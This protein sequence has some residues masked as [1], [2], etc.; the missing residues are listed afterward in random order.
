MHKFFKVI[1]MFSVVTFAVDVVPVLAVTALC[2]LA[3]CF[4]TA[5]PNIQDPTQPISYTKVESKGN[6]A[7]IL[8]AVFVRQSGSQAVI[9][10]RLMQVGDVVQNLRVRRIDRNGVQ[11]AS[12][13]GL[14]RLELR[15]EILSTPERED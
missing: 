6:D 3:A 1:S 9:N 5:Q 7:L 15:P 14:R 11:L 12:S 8:Q 2:S 10:G 4:A 13:D